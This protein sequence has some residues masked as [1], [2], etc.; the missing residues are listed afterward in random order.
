MLALLYDAK[1]FFEANYVK[2]KMLFFQF[3]SIFPVGE[4]RTSNMLSFGC[5]EQTY[6]QQF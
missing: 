2:K 3:I 1:P 5:N 6:F 4:A